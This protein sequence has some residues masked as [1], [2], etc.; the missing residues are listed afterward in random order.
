MD[1][2]SRHTSAIY[3]IESLQFCNSRKDS[4]VRGVQFCIQLY[5]QFSNL[6][7]K[8][9]TMK[10]PRQY[11]KFWIPNECL[12][13]CVLHQIKWLKNSMSNVLFKKLTTTINSN[14][15]SNINLHQIH[16]KIFCKNHVY[17]AIYTACSTSVPTPCSPSSP[18]SSP[19]PTY[20]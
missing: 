12:N 11:S 1:T 9:V 20:S 17:K 18:P 4:T 6:F 2:Y 13:L 19:T 10:S 5:T 3:K 8:L 7:K 15:N 16:F 14:D